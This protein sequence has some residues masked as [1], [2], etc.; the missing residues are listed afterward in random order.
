MPAN[1][2]PVALAICTVWFCSFF[3][4]SRW[5]Y[6]HQSWAS[7]KEGRWRHFCQDF[8]SRPATWNQTRPLLRHW[9]ADCVHLS[10]FC[11]PIKAGLQFVHLQNHSCTYISTLCWRNRFTSLH[12]VLPN[13]SSCQLQ[14]GTHS[15]AMD[16][17]SVCCGLRGW[18]IS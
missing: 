7:D 5:M 15:C 12:P 6:L 2:V 8:H 10:L 4:A 18:S 16:C 17:I 14:H 13:M 11:V 1:W 3:A 9:S